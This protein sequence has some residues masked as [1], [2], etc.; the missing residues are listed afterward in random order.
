MSAFFIR[1]ELILFLGITA[2]YLTASLAAS[3]YVAIKKGM[4][5]LFW[6]PLVFAI[7]HLSYGC[8]FLVGLLKFL[9]RWGDKI[10]AEPQFTILADPASRSAASAVPS[11]PL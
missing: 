6:L 7:L 2:A 4:R 1:W 11:Q 8:G 10:G 9:K 5:N 3:L